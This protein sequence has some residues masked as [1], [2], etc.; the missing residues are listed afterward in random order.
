MA[1]RRA[2]A[3]FPKLKFGNV[4]RNT[5]SQHRDFFERLDLVDGNQVRV[6]VHELDADLLEGPL[7]QQVPFHS[8]KSLVRVVVRLRVKQPVSAVRMASE[9]KKKRAPTS[10]DGDE[11]VAGARVRRR[12]ETLI[13]ALSYACSMRPNSS[14]WF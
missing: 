13:Y 4:S 6:E 1:S 11:C 8:R 3:I 10:S 7:R 5:L 12:R 2:D 9:S 14:R